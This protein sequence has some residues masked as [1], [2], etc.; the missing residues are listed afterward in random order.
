MKEHMDRVH[1][2]MV[3]Y[4]EDELKQCFK[5]A[6][7]IPSNAPTDQINVS[8][9]NCNI[10]NMKFN[11]AQ[12]LFA[13]MMKRHA[14]PVQTASKEVTQEKTPQ[15]PKIQ[16]SAP[17]TE[18]P[19][20]AVI[21]PWDDEEVHCPRCP[22][23]FIGTKSKLRDR[24]RCH[25]GMVHYGRELT[26][27]VK[28]L[29]T[30]DIT[31]VNEDIPCKECGKAYKKNAAK[32]HLLYNHTQYKTQV[33]DETLKSIAEQTIESKP[34][35]KE[36]HKRNA[37]VETNGPE[38]KS[39]VDTAED[40]MKSKL[41]EEI[42]EEIKLES[43]DKVEPDL[44]ISSGNEQQIKDLE[45]VELYQSLG[46]VKESLDQI[47]DQTGESSDQ[48]YT[49]FDQIGNNEVMDIQ[50]QLVQI[51]DE[52]GDRM[53]EFVDEEIGYGEDP[54]NVQGVKES[55]TTKADIDDEEEDT[56]ISGMMKKKTHIW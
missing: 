43:T 42:I 47:N 17:T 40:E 10:C 22:H 37:E 56:Y 50:E 26:A 14:G 39:K 18:T 4:G 6:A 16:L 32:K 21:G 19:P 31:W 35:P 30:N 3:E 13:H 53:Q 51:Q 41:I 5:E 2:D 24:L 44:E 46:Q 54:L 48:N 15:N 8:N 52:D 45:F 36:I 9:H 27:E 1:G 38:K 28:R 29:F 11:M 20:R 55:D 12:H 34:L 25:I 23:K 33:F 7:P 49:N